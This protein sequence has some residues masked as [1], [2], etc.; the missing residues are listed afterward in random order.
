MHLLTLIGRFRAASDSGNAAAR[1]FCE[2]VCFQ[3]VH[4]RPR[5]VNASMPKIRINACLLDGYRIR[6]ARYTRVYLPGVTCP[7][8]AD[9]EGSAKPSPPESSFGNTK[10]SPL[11]V[12]GSPTLQASARHKI[13]DRRQDRDRQ[14]QV[15]KQ[16]GI[17]HRTRVRNRTGKASADRRGLPK[18]QKINACIAQAL[19][20]SIVSGNPFPATLLRNLPLPAHTLEHDNSTVSA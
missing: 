14:G 9:A 8:V 11:A 17:G 7:T 10:K 20:R 3:R 4:R 15:L 5:H 13:E 1:A 2:T 16:V 19:A 12:L 6:S 18:D